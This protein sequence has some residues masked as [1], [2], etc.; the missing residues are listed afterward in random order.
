MDQGTRRLAMVA[1]SIS[2]LAVEGIAATTATSSDVAVVKRVS[3][4][5]VDPSYEEGRKTGYRV[6]H[7]E[8]A[9]W[10]REERCMVVEVDPDPSSHMPTVW[11]GDPYWAGFQDG[12]LDGFGVGFLAVCPAGPSLPS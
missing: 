8:G 5:S 10:A 4:Q 6:G 11:K 1:A 12:Y 2:I 3:P 7:S 9:Q